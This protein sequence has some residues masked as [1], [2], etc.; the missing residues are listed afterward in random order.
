MS[1]NSI[2]MNELIYNLQKSS[3]PQDVLN[4]W[5]LYRGD[6]SKF[7]AIIALDDY[8]QIARVKEIV[9]SL[10][11]FRDCVTFYLNTR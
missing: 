5:R 9:E 10:N 1:L 7:A 6:F 8:K 11:N 4:A 3:N 2:E